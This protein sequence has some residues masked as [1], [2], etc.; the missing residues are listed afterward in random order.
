[1]KNNIFLF[2]VLSLVLFL[3]SFSGFAQSEII[4]DPEVIRLNNLLKKHARNSD[5][6]SFYANKLLKYSEQ[7]KLDYWQ[8]SA[9]VALGN[10][11]RIVGNLIESNVYYHKALDLSKHLLDETTPYRVMNNIAL[12]HKRLRRNDSA[13]YYF[14]ELDT[15]HSNNL[16][17]MSAS[18][19]KMNIGIIFLQ[20]Q[21]LDSAEYYLNNS[22]KGFK[23]LNDK[24]FI[25]QNLNLLGELELQNKAYKLALEYADSCL[26]LAREK[27]LD[28]LLP[29]NYSLH[30]RIYKGMGNTE[31]ADK[32]IKLSQESRPKNVELSD[33]RISNLNDAIRVD[34]AKV[35]ETVLNETKDSKQFFKSN[36]V[37]ALFVILLLAL[38][39]FIFFKR[40]KAIESEFIAI[41]EKIDALRNVKQE[42]DKSIK[43]NVIQLKSKASIKSSQI[44][45]I[46]SDG[47][48]VEYHLDTQKNPE[49]DRNTMIEV[50]KQLP[51]QAF[52][53]IHKSY[54][55]NINRIKIINSNKVMLD[56]GEWINLSRVYKQAL[57]DIL[58]KT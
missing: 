17:V 52:V 58:N 24:R 37:I 46:K 34:K 53:R 33:S 55:V 35:Y 25:A 57:K 18:M 7:N 49:V 6:L 45:Y 50:E 29:T 36:F 56:T 15:Y 39:L 14:K 19:A 20:Y 9:Y 28:F 23:D 13:F 38:I 27:N 5:S 10:S 4:N 3:L 1:M 12:N 22:Y 42:I 41:Q 8:Y 31:L 51:P 2:S 16:E 48:Y 26:V 40:H 54:I 47:H 44:L 11:Q 30:S 32:Y 21:E 43:D